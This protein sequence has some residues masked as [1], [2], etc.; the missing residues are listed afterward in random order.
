VII[1]GQPNLLDPAGDGRT[2]LAAIR[3]TSQPRLRW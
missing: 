3:G 1:A 2:L